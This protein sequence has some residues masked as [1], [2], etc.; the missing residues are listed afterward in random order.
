MSLLL[1]HPIL[2]LGSVFVFGYSLMLITKKFSVPHVVIYIITG[3][4]LSNTV[5]HHVEL[6]SELGIWFIVIENVALGL[7]GFKIG[8]ELKLKSL[9]KEPKFIIIVTLLEVFGAF[10]IVII[11]TLFVTQDFLISL[12]L[13]GLAMAT[14]PAATIEV[15]RKNRAQGELTSKIQWLLA[16]DD[17]VAI[18]FVEAIIAFTKV[19]L[20]GEISIIEYFV[21]LFHEIGYATIIGI[22]VGLILDSVVERLNDDIEMMEFTLAV[23]L[24]AIGLAYYIGTSVILTSMIIGMVATNRTGDNY[25]KAGDLLEIVMSPIIFFFFVAVGTKIKIDYFVPFPTLAIIYLLGRT[26]GKIG[27]AYFGSKI[28]QMPNKISNNLGL[29]LLSQGGVTLGLVAVVNE[30]FL[31]SGFGEIGIEITSTIILSTLLSEIL[32]TLGVKFALNRANEIGIVEIIETKH[33]RDVDIRF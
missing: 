27:G 9:I 21:T 8:T 32:G 11:F 4:L 23:I 10:I 28:I 19:K 16:I 20:L 7:L 18:I 26:L 15:I 30:I 3:F 31:N 33:K 14:A 5:L 25:E 6:E 1:D 24:F 22:I 2:L 13:G 29:G 12:I 17:V